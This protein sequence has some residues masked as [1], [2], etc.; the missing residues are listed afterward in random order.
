M[1]TAKQIC[2]ERKVKTV[3][4]RFGDVVISVTMSAP[5]CSQTGSLLVVIRRR[6]NTWQFFFSKLIVVKFG[7]KLYSLCNSDS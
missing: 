1:K 4:M 3:T 6:R 5:K 7:L 2:R